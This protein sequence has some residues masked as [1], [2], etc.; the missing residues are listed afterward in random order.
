MADTPKEHGMPNESNRMRLS[1]RFKSLRAGVNLYLYRDF[2]QDKGQTVKRT[3]V[4]NGGEISATFVKAGDQ[5]IETHGSLDAQMSGEYTKAAKAAGVKKE[6][7]IMTSAGPVAEAMDDHAEEVGDGPTD[8]GE[9]SKNQVDTPDEPEVTKEAK[10]SPGDSKAVKPAK[11]PEVGKVDNS[12]TKMASIKNGET[13][14]SDSLAKADPSMPTGSDGGVPFDH[15]AGIIDKASNLFGFGKSGN[16]T[17]TGAGN[18]M[19]FLNAVTKGKPKV[20]PKPMTD[21]QKHFANVANEYTKT[22][23]FAG[24]VEKQKG[25]LKKDES[26]MG[27]AAT[28]T[29]DAFGGTA[30]PTPPRGEVNVEHNEHT[31]NPPV[32]GDWDYK[33]PS[34]L[35]KASGYDIK[36]S[37]DTL[38]YTKTNNPSNPVPDKP[39]WQQRWDATSHKDKQALKARL[40]DQRTEIGK[41]PSKT[42]TRNAA[43]PAPMKTPPAMAPMA[44]KPPAVPTTPGPAKKSESMHK[45]DDHSEGYKALIARMKKPKEMKPGTPDQKIQDALR[46]QADA[47]SPYAE[48]RSDNSVNQD[49][50]RRGDQIHPKAK[51]ALEAQRN[52]DRASAAGQSMTQS[53]P[54]NRGHIASAIQDKLNG[55]MPKKPKEQSPWLKETQGRLTQ[56]ENAANEN[57]KPILVRE[58]KRHA[59]YT[60]S[61]RPFQAMIGT[62]DQHRSLAGAHHTLEKPAKLKDIHKMF[63]DPSSGPSRAL[64]DAME[65]GH[66]RLYVH[67]PK[68]QGGTPAKGGLRVMKSIQDRMEAIQKSAEELNR[69]SSTAG[70]GGDLKG[71]WSPTTHPSKPEDL[72]KTDHNAYARKLAG[73]VGK[74]AEGHSQRMEEAK[75]PKPQ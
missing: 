40:S 60:A 55:N 27:R 7:I 48:K 15:N 74:W 35:G 67:Q 38:N 50:A 21:D 41:T 51:A 18:I 11:K 9:T 47:G 29:R 62:T 16:A 46:E 54:E 34:D 12:M 4:E 3:E 39:V 8:L 49:Q 19:K 31:V 33:A 58:F 53:H 10:L 65:G 45:A 36:R 2:T 56:Q 57:G 64:A 26:S 23:Q 13:R 30:S 52:R 25:S 70:S 72:G 6:D 73:D 32:P 44:P 63:S 71:P 24:L 17:V 20:G 68:S 5:T 14:G 61:G 37:G 43:T 28:S 66:D 59:K 22:P 69:S 1:D 42:V 75:N